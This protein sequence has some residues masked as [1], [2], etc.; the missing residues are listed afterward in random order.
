MEMEEEVPRE[1]GGWRHI[2]PA[3]AVAAAALGMAEHEGS[4]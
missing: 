4:M 2:D 3:V 1:E